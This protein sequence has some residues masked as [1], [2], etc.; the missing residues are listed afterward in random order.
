MKIIY[1]TL[2]C[3]H[4]WLK[5]KSN[6]SAHMGAYSRYM[7][8]YFGT[9]TLCRKW[10]IAQDTVVTTKFSDLQYFFV[11][12]YELCSAVVDGVIYQSYCLV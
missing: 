3:K 8:L 9:W 1:R 10:V 12:N 7:H 11:E 4:P 5:H 2:L 6:T